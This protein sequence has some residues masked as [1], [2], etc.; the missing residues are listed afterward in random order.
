MW[1]LEFLLVKLNKLFKIFILLLLLIAFI[2]L[3]LSI[4]TSFQA[5]KINDTYS[6]LN[7]NINGVQFEEIKFKNKSSTSLNGWWVD[8]ESDNAFLMLH[9]LRSNIGD[10]FYIDLISE[11]N[12][13]GFSI[14]A[15]DFRNH[16]KSGEGKFSFG[17][18][19]I[20]D[21]EASIKYIKEN[22]NIENI[23]IW[24]FSFGATTGLNYSIYNTGGAAISGIIADTPYYDPAEVLIDEVS[25]RTPLNSYF[26]KLLKPG[27]IFS[28]KVFF[29]FNLEDIKNIFESEIIN[30]T[31]SLIFGCKNDNTVPNTHPKRINKKLGKISKYIEFENC[32]KHGDA[33]LYNNKKYVYEI[34]NFLNEL[35]EIKNK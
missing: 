35:S 19:E 27:I 3:F 18:E 4:F 14:L 25:K 26:S 10:K 22:K 9:G 21:V 6:E 23:F 24:G 29:N 33:F 12:N 34:N 17:L 28:S 30:N 2:Y 5:F 20:H 11:F 31:P 16:G 15:F 13:L 32:S 7:P 1:A 8:G